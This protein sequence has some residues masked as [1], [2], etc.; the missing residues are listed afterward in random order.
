MRTFKRQ[1]GQTL[2]ETAFVLFL[3]LLILLGITEFARAWYTKNSLK[4][5]ARQGARV[6]AVTTP[7]STIPV[8]FTCID[9]TTCPVGTPVENAVCCQP[10]IPKKANNNTTVTLTCRDSSGTTVTCSGVTAGAEI[11]VQVTSTFYFIVGNS[12]WPWSK[13]MDF[14]TNASMRYEG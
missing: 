2:I 12:P 11:S 1:D 3:L 13:S 7:A 5:A 9:T 14:T 8:S 4:N 10:G 6:A